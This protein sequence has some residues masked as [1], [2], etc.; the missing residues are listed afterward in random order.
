ME[1]NEDVED[2]CYKGWNAHSGLCN[3]DDLQLQVNGKGYNDL[4]LQVNG[5]GLGFCNFQQRC[6]NVVATCSRGVWILLCNRGDGA[7]TVHKATIV[8]RG[9]ALGMVAQ[10]PEKDETSV[11]RKEMLARLDVCMGGR[12]A[13]EL[14]FGE[15]EVTSG[16]SSDLEQ[17]TRLAREMV[18]MVARLDLDN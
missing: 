7:H 1:I 13:E 5:K 18:Y 8:P 14:I 6:L 10:L 2:C 11:S 17:A 12:V 9:M 16:A 15:D 4:H 3:D